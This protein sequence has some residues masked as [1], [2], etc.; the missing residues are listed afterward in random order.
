M[1]EVGKR[2]GNV[3]CWWRKSM[4]EM[5]GLWN[6]LYSPKF[7][8]SICL[9]HPLSANFCS[10]TILCTPCTK[11]KAACKLFDADRACTKAKA[12][13]FW[14]AKVRKTKQQ[15]DAKW[16]MEVLRKLEELSEL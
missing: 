7:A 3:S 6:T 13:A 11:A 14:R 16:K 9:N 5:H 1:R 8:I 4:Q 15:I 12:E 2:S 10:H